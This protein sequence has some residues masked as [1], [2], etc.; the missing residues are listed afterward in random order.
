M[1][2]RVVRAAAVFAGLSLMVAAC[3]ADEET[4]ANEETPATD[5]GGSGDDTATTEEGQTEADIGG[6]GELEGMRGTTPLPETTP[7][8]EA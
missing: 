5:G 2:T 1:S 3:G 8:V 4:T 7:E 6:N